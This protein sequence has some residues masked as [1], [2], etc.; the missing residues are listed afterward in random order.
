MAQNKTYLLLAALLLLYILSVL[1]NFGVLELAGEEPRRAV[2]SLEMMQSGNY[3][4][5]TL[6]GWD[7][8][9]KPPL[10]NWIICASFFIFNST[11][12]FAIRFPSLVFYLLWALVHYFVC[13]K[14]FSRSIALLSSFF[15]LTS[16]DIFFY[17]LAN[18]GEIDIFYSFIV[19]LQAV[20][21][22]YFY[23]KKRWFL[24]FFFSYLF[25]S[26]GFL[27]K[28]F[29]SIAFEVLTLAA[30]CFYDRSF[31][32]LFKWQH[33]VGIFAFLALTG[34]YFF[35]YNQHGT[36]QRLLVNL[37]N[38]SLIKSAV[39]ERSDK[40]L[41]KS[42]GY[43]LLFL[44][45]F[46][47]WSLLLL[48]LLKKIRYKFF[49]NPL[50]AFSLL[51]IVFNIWVYWFTG[52]P[53][54]RYIYMFV[55]FAC[56]V[57]VHIYQQFATAFLVQLNRILGYAGWVF[58]LVLAAIIATPFFIPV[59]L[60]WTVVLAI[61]LAVFIYGYLQLDAYR[62]WLLITGIIL[63]R[64]VYAVLFIPVEYDKKYKFSPG[65]QQ[66]AINNNLQPLTLWAPADTFTVAVKNKLID[67][68]L[69]QTFIAPVLSYQVSYYYF[70]YTGH[71][72][73]FDTTSKPNNNYISFSSDLKARPGKEFIDTN[74]VF[75]H[76][77]QNDTLVFYY[78]KK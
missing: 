55:P 57:L 9:N 10:Y 47:P 52:Q 23:V 41:S 14:F 62:I 67:W 18:G 78:L 34:F 30:L 16:A 1:V 4:S 65:I 8:Y 25:C 6:L 46:A 70:K 69:E 22:F 2:I 48:L 32:V 29:T 15:L 63:T 20:S 60:L 27:T 77:R 7:Y 43:P 59:S 5:P 12:E 26:I 13:K 58:F 76:P 56:V 53:K 42:L 68:K 11:S 64:L 71:L 28:G 49:D 66:A 35:L 44:K 21:I 33:L 37:L 19:Y 73:R 51:F 31:R 36:S 45:L 54:G 72:I 50:V 3:I 17:G 39:G 40:L 74:Y 75:D 24:L 61:I 38:E